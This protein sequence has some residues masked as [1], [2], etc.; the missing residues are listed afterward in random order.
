MICRGCGVEKP[1]EQFNERA[2]ETGARSTLCRLCTAAYQRR[3]YLANRTDLI[4]RAR[5]HRKQA[6]A[7]NRA[8]ANLYLREHPCIDC[9]ETDSV[10]LDFDHTRDKRREI[11]K[12][13]N[14]GFLWSTIELEIA[15]CDVRCA[16]CHARKTARE[17]GYHDRKHAF[18]RI[19]ESHTL[20]RD[21]L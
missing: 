17:R 21:R 7:E 18:R 4:E 19:G 10:V 3:W 15:K 2:E 11:S 20:L 16:N 14:E 12:M 1:L 6:K 5:L 13:I 8:R 9:G